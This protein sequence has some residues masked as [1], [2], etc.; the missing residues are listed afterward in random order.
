MKF[1]R[2]KQIG[3]NKF[4]PQVKPHFFDCW[5]GIDSI[6]KDLNIGF[7]ANYLWSEKDYCDMYCICETLEQA[8]QVIFDYKAN[9]KNKRKYP[10]YLK[11]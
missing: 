8:K 11:S 10:K 4:I 3:E 1:Y 6:H 7:Y 9:Q 5:Y 2:I